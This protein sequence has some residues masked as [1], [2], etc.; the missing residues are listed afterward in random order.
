M[1]SKNGIIATEIMEY[2]CGNSMIRLKK[3][4]F[5]LLSRFGGLSEL[6]YD[7]FYSIANEVVWNTATKYE[8]D[9]NDNFEAFLVTCIINKFKTEMS[10]RNRDRRIPANLINRL[11]APIDSTETLTLG[12]VIDSGFKIDNEIDELSD[13]VR[14]LDIFINNLS[15]KQKSIVSLII[16][17]YDKEEIKLILGMDDK[18][19]NTCIER[20]RSFE[21]RRLLNA[22]I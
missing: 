20:M 5:P 16:D 7:D 2:Y 3:L 18:R 12:D 21:N 10:K 14:N 6:D 15:G 17:G 19:Y 22:S 13:D 1:Q 8:Y 4:C 9:K 11:D